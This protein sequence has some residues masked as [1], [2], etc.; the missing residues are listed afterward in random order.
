MTI[1]EIGGSRGSVATMASESEPVERGALAGSPEAV[2]VLAMQMQEA[3][4]RDRRE[5]SH[6]AQRDQMGVVRQ[7]VAELE[8]AADLR[9]VSAIVGA[10][11]QVGGACMTLGT[12]SMESEQALEQGTAGLAGQESLVGH[13]AGHRADLHG[14]AIAERKAA[15]EIFLAG[16]KAVQAVVERA[17]SRAV[18]DAD[19][20]GAVADQHGQLAAELRDESQRETQRADRILQHLAEIGDARRQAQMVAARG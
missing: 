4:A 3:S 8:R 2:L 6:A 5:A 16:S 15:T 17:G 9:C 13:N 20:L 18:A 10:A 1:S 11:A 12:Q 7:R 19:L 14:T